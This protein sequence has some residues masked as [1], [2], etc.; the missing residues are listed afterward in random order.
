MSIRPLDEKVVN[1]IAAGEIVVS[2]ANALKE[3]LENA[4]D[5]GSAVVNVVAAEGG[6]KLLQV[7]DAGTGIAKEDLPI[8]AQRFTTSKLDSFEGLS[9]LSTYGFRGEALASISH[10]SRL[11]VT[12]RT[13]QSNV[14]YR[15]QYRDGVMT[16]DPEPIAGRVGTTITIEDMFYNNRSRLA[17]FRSHRDEFAKIVE[18]VARYAI[19]CATVA[20]T[21]K[22]QGDPHFTISLNASMSKLNRLKN[23]FGAVA[24]DLIE[25]RLQSEDMATLGLRSALCYF[26]KPSYH[27][28][29]SVPPVF[30]INGRLV[31]CDP[32]RRGLN[33]IYSSFLQKGTH[34]FVYLEMEVDPAILDV[35]IHP[36][37]REVRFLNEEEIISHICT[38]VLNQLAVADSS[39]T[40]VSQPV[41]HSPAPARMAL[42][43]KKTYENRLVRTSSTQQ[44]ITGLLFSQAKSKMISRSTDTEFEQVQ[45]KSISELRRQIEVGYDIEATKIFSGHAYVG[46]IDG[47]KRL[48]AVQYDIRLLL[49]DYGLA[50]FELF[51]QLGL[52]EFANFGRLELEPAVNIREM[53]EL[54][55][56]ETA[57]LSDN[58]IQEITTQLADASEML[59][60]Y[61]NMDITEDG[62]LESIPLLLKGYVPSLEKLPSFLLKLGQ[63]VDWTQEK[64]FFDGFLRQLAYFYVPLP[65]QEGEESRTIEHVLF[66]AFKKYLIASSEVKE[67]IVELANLPTLYK[68]FE[69]C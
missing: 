11:T 62:Y 50:A 52:S 32:L 34:S 15:A 4:L 48:A 67:S 55:R 47:K 6:L 58:D 57:N 23:V 69:R 43:P 12:T 60:E 37:K 36:T 17:A 35:N 22:K 25:M 59:S 9:S 49:V 27:G 51:Y 20:F 53:L 26:T 2:P 14:A 44:K 41:S 64:Q 61:F 16:G 42:A 8:L 39:H 30:F 40:F 63:A 18:V 54:S 56:K 7:S 68:V 65:L 28:K 45:L 24:N 19:K 33:N 1:R 38:S 13:Q 21:V 3:V 10:V 46:I 5:A 31:Q 29:K 66:P